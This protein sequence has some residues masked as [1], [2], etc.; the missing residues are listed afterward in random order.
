[1]CL[2]ADSMGLLGSLPLEAIAVSRLDVTG[3]FLVAVCLQHG[4]RHEPEPQILHYL[5]KNGF[6]SARGHR[7]RY[8]PNNP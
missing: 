1:V 3:N 4:S 7:Q 2:D 5:F 6:M 8:E